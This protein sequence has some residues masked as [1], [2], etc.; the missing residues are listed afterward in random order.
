V[1]R[2]GFSMESRFRVTVLKPQFY[3]VFATCCGSTNSLHSQFVNFTLDPHVEKAVELNLAPKFSEAGSVTVQA[4][5]L[6]LGVELRSTVK[7]ADPARDC[8]KI[9][10]SPALLRAVLVRYWPVAQNTALRRNL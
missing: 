9:R 6:I 8:C 1:D 5:P 10:Q 7:S 2:F 3:R 4:L